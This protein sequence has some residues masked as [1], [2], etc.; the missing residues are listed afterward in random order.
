MHVHEKVYGKLLDNF[1][2]IILYMYTVVTS[3]KL[4][5]IYL[6]L[7]AAVCGTTNMYT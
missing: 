3:T 4:Q 5:L 6:K 1:I 2:E 7:H